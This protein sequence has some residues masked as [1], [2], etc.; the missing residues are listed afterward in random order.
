MNIAATKISAG[1]NT[2]IGSHSDD[3]EDSDKGR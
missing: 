1:V 3:I 2:G